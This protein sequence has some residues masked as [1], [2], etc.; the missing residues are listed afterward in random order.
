MV[1]KALMLLGVLAIVGVAG[2]SLLLPDA[3]DASEHSAT[4]SFASESVDAG[5]ELEIEISVS[6]LGGAG[7]VRETLP[8]GFSFVSS[9]ESSTVSG[10][11]VSFIVLGDEATFSYTVAA[12]D[13]GG[14][15][16]FSGTV[17]DFD[18][19]VQITGGDI[20]IEVIGMEIIAP[21]FGA[22]RSI[23]R[24][25]VSSGERVTVNIAAQEF[26]T[27]ASIV[28]SLPAG[29]SFAAST[30]SSAA[31]NVGDDSIRFTLLE[32]D[33]LSYTLIA[34]DP[35]DYTFS[36]TITGFDRE[37]ADITGDDSVSVSASAPASASRSFGSNFVD[38]GSEVVVTIA[39]SN[40]G[41]AGQ[42]SETI[43][44]GFTYVSTDVAGGASDVSGQTIVLTILGEDNV[45]YTVSAP[46][47]EGPYTFSGT[48]TDIDKNEVATG[49]DSEL[50]VGNPAPVFPDDEGAVRSVPENTP[51]GVN[52]GGPVAAISPIGDLTYEITSAA[53]ADFD[54]DSSSGQ[55]LTKAPLD[56]ETRS[57]Y[58]LRIVAT[59]SV[60][61]EVSIVVTVKV[62][63]VFEPEPTATPEPTPVPPTAT[64]QPTATPEPTAVPPTATT[65]AVEP[66]AMPEPE[67]EEDEGGFPIWAIIVI[68]LAVVGGV[69]VIGFVAMRRRA[70]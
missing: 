57:S 2:L 7:Q 22:E 43:P 67:V 15:Y 5:A 32:G 38:P 54:I 41:A 3:V 68:V 1:K 12:P 62:L 25:S 18:K 19:D 52:V 23:S 36:G 24:S 50:R 28:E 8:D 30:L 48:L 39:A 26:G 6:G 63:D 40:Y 70:G 13:A 14:T 66:T 56:Y 21:T 4:R 11:T 49:G 44:D 34:G 65:P 31:V 16:E 47:E 42:V 37:S 27:A 69:A 29:F 46:E 55:I 53:A 64:P 45:S 10:Q 35:G 33:A 60:G 59:D 58:S 17:A 51:A 20:A 9:D 61:A